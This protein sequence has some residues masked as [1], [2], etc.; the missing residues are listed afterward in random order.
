MY[1]KHYSAIVEFNQTFEVATF[2]GNVIDIFDKEKGN[3]Q[4]LINKLLLIFEEVDETIC[5]LKDFDFIEIID[6]LVDTIYVC[7]GALYCINAEG[8]ISAEDLFL[9]ENHSLYRKQLIYLRDEVDVLLNSTSSVDKFNS[10][11]LLWLLSKYINHD[12]FDL[13]DARKIHKDL[14][15]IYDII[16]M[17]FKELISNLKIYIN[18]RDIFNIIKIINKIRNF[19][20]YALTLFNVDS[21]FAFDV[22]HKSNMSKICNSEI[23]AIAT[24]KS[25]MTDGKYDS[26][27]YRESQVPGKWIVYNHSTNK[28]LKSI[29]YTAV[30]FYSL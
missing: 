24:V 21:N 10:Q 5:A 28:V 4:L 1:N 22:V 19:A 3:E 30:N 23:E 13:I 9:K 17:R 6:G 15:V 16:S 27:T 2:K 20:Y 14:V 29:N 7:Y 26:P 11:K 12:D 8:Y 18:T 25:Y